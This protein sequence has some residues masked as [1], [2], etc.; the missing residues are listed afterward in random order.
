MGNPKLEVNDQ[1]ET[2]LSTEARAARLTEAVQEAKAEI[3]AAQARRRRT[4]IVVVAA[5][6]AVVAGVLALQ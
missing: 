5:I 2:I 1:E 4:W 6:L 3:A